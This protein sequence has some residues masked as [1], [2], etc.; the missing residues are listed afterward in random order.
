MPKFDDEFT[1]PDE[2]NEKAKAKGKPE[3]EKL[4][5]EIEDDTP[6]EDRGRAPAEPP[7]EVTDDELASYDEKVQKR[8]QIH[9]H[10][11]N[12]LLRVGID[13][14]TGAEKQVLEEYVK[15]LSANGGF[16]R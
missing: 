12:A 15:M 3:E 7:E 11:W 10:A 5:I 4:A 1:F 13:K 16:K 14:G 2:V 6:A 8:G 9:E